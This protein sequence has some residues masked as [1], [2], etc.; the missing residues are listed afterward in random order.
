[1]SR[2]FS[3]YAVGGKLCFL[4]SIFDLSGVTCFGRKTRR[5]GRGH[6]VWTLLY[7]GPRA[8][9]PAPQ[10]SELAFALLGRPEAQLIPRAETPRKAPLLFHTRLPSSSV[11][12]PCNFH[13]QSSDGGIV[14]ISFYLCFPHFKP[15]VVWGSR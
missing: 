3:K 6:S 11:P 4:C 10:L 9:P 1:M 15:T 12:G 13:D 2:S 8:L 5:E 14:L 7:A